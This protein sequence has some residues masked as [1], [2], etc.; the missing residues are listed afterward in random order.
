MDNFGP[1]NG[2]LPDGTKPSPEPMLPFHQQSPVTFIWGSFHKRY[3]VHQPL[4]LAWK[5]P[6]YNFT[7]NLP[8]GNELI[9]TINWANSRL[10]D[11]IR[12]FTDPL[13]HRSKF[14]SS[15]IIHYFVKHWLRVQKKVTQSQLEV[16][17]FYE[18]WNNI[19]TIVYSTVYSCADQRKHQSSASLAFVR[20][21]H[22]SPVITTLSKIHFSQMQ[23]WFI[24]K[25]YN[26]WI[27][28][29]LFGAVN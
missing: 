20:G 2:L 23:I 5:L 7:Q 9:G 12:C 25:I 1:G 21:I 28:M 8:G 11:E 19:F 4:K 27:E 18:N 14:Y 10:I 15:N 29:P 22:Q 13:R 17:C 6:F 26:C 16:W 24:Q 3:F